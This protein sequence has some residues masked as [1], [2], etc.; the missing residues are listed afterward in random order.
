MDSHTSGGLSELLNKFTGS[1]NFEMRGT[2]G[3]ALIILASF[4]S[5]SG[6]AQIYNEVTSDRS[7]QGFQRD[8]QRA[9]GRGISDGPSSNFTTDYAA[10]LIPEQMCQL[11]ARN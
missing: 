2:V 10:E 9:I 6:Q 3:L 5:A 7:V 4:W 8:V 1:A 11:E